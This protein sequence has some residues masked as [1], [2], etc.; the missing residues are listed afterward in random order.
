[1]RPR[2]RHHVGWLALLIFI[3]SLVPPLVASSHLL[4]DPDPDCGT[5][6]QLAGSS[7]ASV[8]AVPAARAPE[9]CAICHLLRSLGGAAPTAAMRPAPAFAMA[10]SV[11]AGAV[12]A[13]GYSPHPHT[14]SRAP[15]A[16]S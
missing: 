8:G 14:P 12:N 2:A 4:A 15:P 6:F 11:I 1:M 5:S 10:E 13:S 16:F 7:T 9:H 3:G